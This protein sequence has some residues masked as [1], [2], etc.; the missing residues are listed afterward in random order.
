[1]VTKM[2]I[3]KK[4]ILI[5]IIFLCLPINFIKPHDEFKKIVSGVL[6]AFQF[7]PYDPD[8]DWDNIAVWESDQ[9]GSIPIYYK[10]WTST[11]LPIS[12]DATLSKT[13]MAEDWAIWYGSSGVFNFIET[14]YIGEGVKISFSSNISSF[15]NPMS[16][17]G[18]TAL[19]VEYDFDIGEKYVVS[20]P[21]PLNQGINDTEI[22]FNSTPGFTGQ[23]N[24][25]NYTEDL[26]PNELC[27]KQVALH[28]LGHLIGLAECTRSEAVMYAVIHPG[29]D[30]FTLSQS[31]LD[32]L[33]IL[34][35]ATP[36]C[37]PC[38]PEV[39]KNFNATIVGQ[40]VV[41]TW[42]AYDYYVIGFKVYKNGQ[43]ITLP[44][45]QTS[46]T[47]VGAVNSLPAAFKLGGYNIN[48]ETITGPINVIVSPSAINSYTLWTRVIYV[49]SNVNVSSSANLTIGAN[50]KIIFNSGY[51]YNLT[52]NGN[53]S[54][55]GIAL[56]PIL[57]SSNASVPSSGN[58]GSISLDGSSATNSILDNVQ[59]KYG[60][61]IRCLNGANVI[62]RNSLI[63][64]CTYG[65]YIYNSAP[66]IRDNSIIDPY[67]NGIYGEANGKSP[68]IKGNIIK[69]ITTNLYNYQGIYLQNYTNP[70]ITAN[71]IKE[72]LHGIYYGGGG[73]GIFTDNS[74]NTPVKNNRLTYNRYGFTVA[75]G[76]YLIAGTDN[77][78]QD[79]PIPTYTGHKNS[80]FGNT[81]YDAWVYQSGNV[82][83]RYNW[84]GTDGI[85]V[86]IQTN[87]YINVSN[88]LTS[89]PWSGIPLRPVEEEILS[90]MPIEG[91]TINLADILTGLNLESE[92]RITE[93]VSH[94]KKML[95]N[96]SHPKFALVRL[97]GIKN[98]YS[99]NNIQNYLETLLIGNTAYKP[100]I[101]NL[102]AGI[103]LND[104]RYEEAMQLY[105]LIINGYPNSYD[106]INALF[107]KFFAALHYANDLNLASQLLSQ[108]QS[109]NITDEDFLMR[110]GIAESMLNEASSNGL[111]KG[112]V[113]NS[114]NNETN[115]PKEYTLLGNYP[116]PFN[117]STTI[118]YALPFQSSVELIIYDIMG[119][120][121]KSFSIP[122][123]SS[124]YQNI[125]WNGT[126]ENG[127]SVASGIY[128]YRISSKSLENNEVFVKTSKLMMLK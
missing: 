63:D 57:F 96:I 105:N 122:S 121:I 77:Y 12:L 9:A 6:T 45:N 104:D 115:S 24:W 28:E 98:R 3:N 8:N 124:G 50:T 113:A 51:N 64:H 110:L 65:I 68:V 13:Q 47:Y 128:L 106:A 53:L 73:S 89:D 16:D 101:L 56:G 127:N 119:R 4:L 15:P 94:Y 108:L 71:D 116:N 30:F 60:A 86:K 120:E 20:T 66:T 55:A 7:D 84:W 92:E 70:F 43:Y 88:P 1:M 61:G 31:D 93:A 100:T 117:P 102:I 34:N 112:R 40:N 10:N 95:R 72:F 14:Q 48:G 114:K 59:V 42:E 11:Y 54:A 118:S 99:V 80:I 22:L 90:D 125:I 29:S 123:Q 18:V 126:N 97:V 26:L 78:E 81:Y 2:T 85:Q 62:I 21:F 82:Q 83:A 52:I 75:W 91:D 74:Y 23:F 44:N 46:Y 87:G 5:T 27:F 76:S 111:F 41:L 103:Y 39:P 49:N 67:G 69:K 17:G 37:D 32:G 109:L 19:A 38:P 107:E 33:Y 35:T 79:N 58:W 25:V 36:I